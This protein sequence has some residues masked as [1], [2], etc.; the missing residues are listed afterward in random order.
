MA[1]QPC[2]DRPYGRTWADPHPGAVVGDLDAAEVAAGVD[3]D[4]VRDRLPG[5]ARTAGAERE[6]HAHRGAEERRDLGRG[7]CGHRRGRS[8]GEVRGVVRHP[9]PV[10]GP[11]GDGAGPYDGGEAVVQVGGIGQGHGTAPPSRSV[12][13]LVT[14]GLPLAERAGIA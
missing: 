7:R 9:Q 5:P 11:G 4:A 12:G 14:T 1:V 2:I 3:Q 13:W 10:D 6:R 8:A